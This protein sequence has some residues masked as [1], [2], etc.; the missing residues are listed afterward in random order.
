MKKLNLPLL[1]SLIIGTMVTVVGVHLLHG[2]QVS[3]SVENLL[4]RADKAAEA[5]DVD[6]QVRLLTRYLRHRKEDVDN[7]KKLLKIS[8]EQAFSAENPSARAIIMVLDSLEKAVREYP[9][10]QDLRREGYQAFLAVGR[11]TDALDH[12]NALSQLEGGITPKDR[13]AWARVL[14]LSN[15]QEKGL[16]M[17]C[18][19]TGF[20][21]ATLTFDDA[22]ATAPDQIGAYLLL[23]NMYLRDKVENDDLTVPRQIVDKG[24]E[25]N[26]SDVDA[27]LGRAVFLQQNLEGNEGKEQSEADVRKALEL[28]PNDARVI[29]VAASTALGLRDFTWAEQLVQ[30]GIAKHP[31]DPAMYG[32][33]ADVKKAQDQTEAALDFV[34]RG[35]EKFQLN[36]ELLY[37]RAN[38]EI[39][40]DRIA[41]ARETIERL[42]GRR[43]DPIRV[44]LL[45]ARVSM[46]GNNFVDARSRLEKLRPLT[47]SG[48][49]M[50]NAVKDFLATCYRRLNMPD[51]I[52]PLYGTDTTDNIQLRY[53]QAE[54]FAQQGRIQDAVKIYLELLEKPDQLTPEGKQL[55]FGRL[56]ALLIQQERAKPE[57]QRDWSKVDQLAAQFLKRDD[58]NQ[59]EKELFAIDMLIRKG[60][61]EEARRIA[62]RASRSYPQI[63]RF[64][65]VL[66]ELSPD[67]DQAGTILNRIE[68][69]FGDSAALRIARGA[70]L[71]KV[72]GDNVG[73]EL[74]K[75]EEGLERFT[76]QEQQAVLQNLATLY[77][78]AGLPGKAL[79]IWRELLPKD[80]NSIGTR[81]LMFELAEA[82]DDLAGMDEVLKGM[83]ELAGADSPE[84]QVCEANRQLWLAEQGQRS[85]ENLQDILSLLQKARNKRPDFAPIYAIQAEVQ[86]M[87]GDLD[88][89]IESWKTALQKR[90]GEVAY[91]QRLADVLMQNKRVPEAMAILAQLPEDQKRLGDV[92]SE[93]RALLSRDPAAALA[94]ARESFSAESENAEELTFLYEV[95]Q[96]AGKTAEGLP[97]LQRAIKFAPTT[98]RPWML[99]VSA[100]VE[101]GRK[102]DA[103]KVIEEAQKRVDPKQRALLVGQ[104]YAT[105]GDLPAAEESLDEALKGDPGNTVVLRNKALILFA[106]QQP[107]KLADCLDQII[108][109]NKSDD[110]ETQRNVAWARRF[111]AQQLAATD[112]YQDFL[113]GLELV[114]QNADGQGQ[115]SGEDLSLWLRMCANRSEAES[116]RKAADRLSEIRSQ[117]PLTSDETVILAYIYNN[118][119]R[120]NESRSLMIDVL[121]KNPGNAAFMTTYIDWLLERKEFSDAEAWIRK[122]NPNSIEYVR[123]SSILLA[124]QGKAADAA[125]ALMALVP[126]QITLL[127]AAQIMEDLGKYDARFYKAAKQQW[128]KHVDEHPEQLNTYIEF[129]SRMP[130]G[131]GIGEAMQLL[132][133][134]FQKAVEEKQ[135][136]NASYC[137]QTMLKA[138]RDHKK[139]IPA[140]SPYAARIQ[141]W[142]DSAT[143]AGVEEIALAWFQIDFA[144]IQ[145]DNKTLM[146]I[147]ETLLKR[148]DIS[149]LQQAV[150]RNN[151]AFL[152]AISNEGNKALEI[153]ADANSQL[154]PR[155]DFLDTRGLAYLASGKFDAALKDLRDAV[156]GGQGGAPTYF[157][158]ALAEHR[159]GNFAEAVQA[160]E[161]AEAKGMT[162]ADLSKPEVLLY[163][164]LQKELQPHRTAP[165]NTSEPR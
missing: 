61:T 136:A 162:E 23:A 134:V 146:T 1:L 85:R 19:M 73:T 99:Y 122:L 69:T 74:A 66:S 150:I 145:G 90:P 50:Q 160:I 43:F 161:Q 106:T 102:D 65:L 114:E 84:W 3:R 13:V 87:R 5:G 137:L 143:R 32:R 93:I 96:A 117:R 52:P 97:L 92:L 133:P 34:D 151:I 81:M 89:S 9:D 129:L 121:A 152:Y 120:W 104:C 20:D 82:A 35:L 63:Q 39:D 91:L 30:D 46:A 6:E 118:Q 116:Q 94:R 22:A 112:N 56:L 139:S 115:L 107:Q 95:H 45:R 140:D 36:G 71:L 2:Y 155:S 132:D 88:A 109:V 15:E 72:G 158:L 37:K 126:R 148:S 29:L 153:L 18:E 31:D 154:G 70:R 62:E 110:D 164:Q 86:A 165:T 123:Y 4:A 113:K 57:S 124:Q 53:N 105:I 16:G 17:L 79:D 157:H 77:R 42:E 48:S 149:P 10:D 28:A 131:A 27:F 159:N 55:I 83:A 100:L 144:D 41:A 7:L 11:F 142:L 64:Q 26:S 38:Y 49:M 127:T 135:S 47:A 8:R 51:L 21:L 58:L 101:L 12:L 76:D 108:A 25:R 67:L 44:E 119:G 78:R 128:K 138:L 111:K 80:P 68:Q 33:M 156:A 14:W 141:S 130:E 54:A 147:Y 40:L 103:P 59:P 75:L 125:R 98:P 24:V 163:R 60:Q